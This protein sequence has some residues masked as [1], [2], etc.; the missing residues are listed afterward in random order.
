MAGESA[1]STELAKVAPTQG[2]PPSKQLSDLPKDELRALAV[3]FGLDPNEFHSR[4]ALVAAIHDRRQM[5][6]GLDREAMMDV[7]RWAR[8]PVAITATKELLAH[9]IVQIK[10][11]RFSG[12]PH[13]G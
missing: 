6:A 2:V 4:Q 8:R 3:T 10:S 5:I 1:K 9:E 11:M 12:L 13:R 7:I